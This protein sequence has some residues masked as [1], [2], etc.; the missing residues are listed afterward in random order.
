MKASFLMLIFGKNILPGT[1]IRKA[2]EMAKSCG[3]TMLVFNG[4]VYSVSD[5]TELFK[6]EDIV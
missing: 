2:R 3:Y 5:G 4:M 1:H 6:L